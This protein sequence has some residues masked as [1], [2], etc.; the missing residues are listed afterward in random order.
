MMMKSTTMI[1][2]ND[3]NECDKTDHDDHHHNHC[4][5][6]KNNYSGYQ[7]GGERKVSKEGDRYTFLSLTNLQ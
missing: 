6:F 3:D 5:H 4:H 7:G 1:N 2:D